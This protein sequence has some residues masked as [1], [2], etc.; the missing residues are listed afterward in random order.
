MRAFQI[1]APNKFGLTEVPEP[2][3]AAGECRVR[4]RLAGI[5]RTDLELAKGYMDFTGI[6]GHEFVGTVASGPERLLGRRVVG[7]INAACGQC[8]DCR[9]GLE[10][11][12]AQRTVLGIYK[13]PGAFAETPSPRNWNA[14]I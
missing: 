11:H 5:C 1:T 4:V 3:L 13:R 12:C 2:P 9:R 14:R 10:R 8:D 6:P 7:E